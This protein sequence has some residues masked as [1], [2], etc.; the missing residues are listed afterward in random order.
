MLRNIVYFRICNNIE[1][2]KDLCSRGSK[3]DNII[4]R[5]IVKNE[6]NQNRK[7]DLN[8]RNEAIENIF[9]KIVNSLIKYK[10]KIMS[11]YSIIKKL[12]IDGYETYIICKATLKTKI[13]YNKLINISD[14]NNNQHDN[15]IIIKKINNKISRITKSNLNT[16]IILSKQIKNI[17]K[18]IKN[19][20]K[21]RNIHNIVENYDKNKNLY[22]NYIKEIVNNVIQLKGEMPEEQSIYILIK[23]NKLQNVNKI[24]NMVSNYKT[25]NIVTPNVNN[26]I[27]LEN[28]LEEAEEMLTILNNKR[29]SLARAKYIIN[30]DFTL[31]EIIQYNICRTAVIFNL[32]N[33]KLLN[34]RNFD[35]IIINN[36]KI[37]T[38]DKEQFDLQDE[39]I[40]GISNKNEEI[41]ERIKKCYYNLIGNNEYINF[42][43]LT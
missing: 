11:R 36:I 7:K 34:M 16:K 30:V 8:K 2:Y 37:K 14:I 3:K 32:S 35:G 18:N 29:K 19:K 26:F 10:F 33:F 24:I 13:L 21:I 5:K 4:T 1:E 9:N 28:N 43:E 42:K 23:E 40:C 27:K 17:E 25:I 12:E 41:L 15:N 6:L 20:A 38:Y 22:N 39:Y 31:E